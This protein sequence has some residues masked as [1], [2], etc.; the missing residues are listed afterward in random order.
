MKLSLEH[1]A[2]CL[3]LFCCSVGSRDGPG[4]AVILQPGHPVWTP[5]DLSPVPGTGPPVCIHG[6]H[7]PCHP[8][9]GGC[10]VSPTDM[11]YLVR[12]GIDSSSMVDV[13]NLKITLQLILYKVS[14]QIYQQKVFSVN[15]I[16]FNFK[17]VTCIKNP[18][19]FL[20][21][22]PNLFI[23]RQFGGWTEGPEAV[24]HQY[25]LPRGTGI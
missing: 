11:Y 20:S 24:H 8:Q 2:L 15:I 12:S 18:S 23:F 25:H 3:T 17:P 4:Q 1:C 13:S 19:L 5:H 7:H 21:F 6:R 10:H 14:G 16:T 9:N 22:H